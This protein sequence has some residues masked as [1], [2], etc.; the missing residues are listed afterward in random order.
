MSGDRGQAVR[1]NV[2]AKSIEFAILIAVAFALPASAQRNFGGIPP[3]VTS[4]SPFGVHAPPPLPSVTSIPNDN[5]RFNNFN[6]G[7]RGNHRGRGGYG[8]GYPAYTVPYYYPF[9]S[10]LYGSDYMG[11]GGGPDLYSG[12]P[13][14][15]NE[16]ILHVIVEQP[17]ASAYA[18]PREEPPQPQAAQPA[19]AEVPE[20]KPGDPTLLVF[21]NGKHE[22]VTN[23]AIMGDTL[24]VFDQGRKKIALA[25]LDLP[26]TVKANDDRGME[27]R[28]PA[29]PAKKKAAAPAPQSTE[30]DGTSVQPK[31]VAALT[32]PDVSE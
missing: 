26:A 2:I 12:P 18:P 6:N 29:T 13:P 32:M 1:A 17:P 8:Y 4:T 25:D 9:D 16:S 15:P 21:R 31:K 11:G 20:V 22:E 14:G 30:P 5:F 10:S 23:Y 24:Y 19:T 28:V 27:F 7:F 3:S